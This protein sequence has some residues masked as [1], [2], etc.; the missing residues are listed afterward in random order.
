MWPI[1]STILQVLIY[2]C[3]TLSIS[4]CQALGD[5]EINDILKY[6]EAQGIYWLENKNIKKFEEVT[7]EELKIFCHNGKYFKI[8]Q[9]I[10]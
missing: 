7:Y 5:E 1:L 8:E 4:T 6:T 2:S 9:Q 10:N 3:L